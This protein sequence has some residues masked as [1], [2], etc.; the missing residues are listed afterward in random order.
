MPDSV[1]PCRSRRKNSS[2]TSN[3]IAGVRARSIPETVPPSGTKRIRSAVELCVRSAGRSGSTTDPNPC[4][5]AL[6][7][8][9]SDVA[10]SI[11]SDR[12]VSAVVSSSA[13]GP[14]ASSLRNRPS[15]RMAS[16]REGVTATNGR[17]CR[18]F[19]DTRTI[20]PEAGS[21]TFGKSTQCSP[22]SSSTFQ[23]ARYA[24]RRTH[25]WV[26]KEMSSGSSANGTRALP[27]VL[28]TSRRPA[29]W[30]SSVVPSRPSGPS[31]NCPGDLICCVDDCGG[32]V[33]H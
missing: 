4:E 10:E 13:S 29:N 21:E 8:E 32:F 19:R 1:D 6:L 22:A 14:K 12:S 11:A 30:C 27:V 5:M 25:S 18:S 2:G 15:V 9:R 17:S 28:Q 23:I 33:D 26:S 7:A 20:I 24:K 31:V 3:F 16:G